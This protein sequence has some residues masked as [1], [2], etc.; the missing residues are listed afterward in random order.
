MLSVVR[1]PCGSGSRPGRGRL[2]DVGRVVLWL[3]L[4][5]ARPVGA[6]PLDAFNPAAPDGWLGPLLPTALYLPAEPATHGRGPWLGVGGGVTSS[7]GERR[8]IFGVVEIGIPLGDLP[9]DAGLGADAPWGMSSDEPYGDPEEGEGQSNRGISAGASGHRAP[10]RRRLD[11]DGAPGSDPAGGV[12]AGAARP[13]VGAASASSAVALPPRWP[14]C[15][16]TARSCDPAALARVARAA[17]AEALRVHGGGAELR[18]LDGMAARS[19]AAASLPEVRLG[20][21]TSRDESLRLAPTAADPARFTRD[22]GRDLWLEARLTWRL[23]NA[24]F[25]RD[26]IAIMRL[27]AQQREEMTRLGA[28]VLEAVIS[29]ERARSQLSSALATTEEREQALIT[30]FG[31]AARLDVLTNGWF[32]RQLEP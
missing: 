27:R 6:S 32:S 24:I 21:G 30:Q 31:A 19:R 10:L 17:V 29:F 26:E 18:R 22:G 23:D 2:L 12:G 13:E 9:L 14:A 28:R 20:A 4:S 11:I 5:L 8:R 16:G 3:G 15:D 25:A 7:P 1:S